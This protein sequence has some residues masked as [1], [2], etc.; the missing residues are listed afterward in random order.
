MG[1]TRRH[2]PN[3]TRAL[4]RHRRRPPK[5]IQQRLQSPLAPRRPIHQ[6]P[7][8]DRL[9]CH[10]KEKITTDDRAT[11]DGRF[12]LH[13]KRKQTGLQTNRAW[14]STVQ[15]RDTSSERRMDYG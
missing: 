12:F 9:L 3:R 15:G 6:L 8:P 4:Q 1:Q 13:E 11:S 5:R 10:R 7:R 14:K 2:H